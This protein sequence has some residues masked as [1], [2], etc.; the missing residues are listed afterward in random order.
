VEQ[1]KDSALDKGDTACEL[2]LQTG[3]QPGA[4]GVLFTP[5]EN[6]S[7]R[8]LSNGSRFCLTYSVKPLVK[9]QYIKGS[10]STRLGVIWVDWY[11]VSVP[12]PEDIPQSD[13]ESLNS[14]GP[15]R[16]SEPPT[17]KFRGPPCYIED[18]PFETVL[19]SLPPSPRV[20]IPFEMSYRISNKTGMQQKLSILMSDQS[21]DRERSNVSEGVL[22]SGLVNGDIILSPFESQT[23]SYTALATKA[24]KTT[25]PALSI[26]S[27]RYKTWLVKD[28]HEG[29]REIFVLP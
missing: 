26:S 29:S 11:P 18:A 12:L 8:I 19:E 4:P 5:K 13:I 17:L 14:H 1:E 25:M 10:V 20:A 2:R 6:D 15:L 24:G 9:D 27:D 7:S 22:V 28:K 21:D 16:L 3:T 23:L